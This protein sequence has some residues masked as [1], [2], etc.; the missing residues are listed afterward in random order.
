M[1]WKSWGWISPWDPS[2]AGPFWRHAKVVMP[3]AFHTMSDFSSSESPARQAFKDHY[4]LVRRVVPKERMLEYKVQD[5]WGPLCEFLNVDV[6]DEEYPKVNDAEQFIFAH[7]LMWW[8]AL[9]KM[10]AKIGAMVAVPAVGG[11]VA[12]WWQRRQ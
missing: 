7:R 3:A 1:R 4:A 11:A 6:P 8:L 5:G 2:L 12:M 9:G 10:A